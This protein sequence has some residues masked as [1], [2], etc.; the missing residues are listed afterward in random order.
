MNHPLDRKSAAKIIRAEEHLTT[1]RSEI[2]SCLDQ[3]NIS[4][5]RDPQIDGLFHFVVICPD[6]DLKLSIVI[7]ECLH[8]LRSALDHIVWPN[9]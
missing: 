5:E 3:G 4:S 7:G 6:P 2:K 8:N 1:I 9:R